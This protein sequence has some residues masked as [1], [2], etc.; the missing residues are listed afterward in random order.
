[1]DGD[2]AMQSLAQKVEDLL[3]KRFQAGVITVNLNN[4]NYNFATVIFPFAF[5]KVPRVTVGSSAGD[6]VASAL[7]PQTT[8]FDAGAF[9]PAGPIT[10]T[11]N[12]QWI[13]TDLY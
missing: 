1:M 4:Q 9:R 13:A 8:G 5:T 11:V 10:Y 12:V 3:S 6:F 2:N 7:N